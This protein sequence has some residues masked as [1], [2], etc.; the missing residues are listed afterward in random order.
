MRR[1]L[2]CSVCEEIESA[3]RKAFIKCTDTSRVKTKRTSHME[4]VRRER[5]EYCEKRDRAWFNPGQ[6][7][8]ILIDG[9][10]QSSFGL[11]HF[12]SSTKDERGNSLKVKHLCI[13]EPCNNN[14][15]EALNRFI[16]D[17]AAISALPPKLHMQ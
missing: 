4:F 8:S 9:A 6:Y 10:N 16:K 13:F 3:C 14:I 15:V 5:L 2:K 1:S 11:P 12:V 17:K 7:F